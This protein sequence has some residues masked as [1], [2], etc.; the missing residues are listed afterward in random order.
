MPKVL[1][2][3]G[4][5]QPKLQQ[6]SLA[7][8][9]TAT[10]LLAAQ[11][12]AILDDIDDLLGRS[13]VRH[14]SPSQGG[15]FFSGPTGTW[16]TL[17]TDATRLQSKIIEDYRR[18]FAT[19]SVLLRGLPPNAAKEL[20][21]SDET[22]REVVEQ[23]SST[24]IATADEAMAKAH[25]AIEAQRGLLDRLHDAGGGR[26]VFVPD[27]NAL[28]YNIELGDWA[29]PGSSSF[30]LVLAPSV[31][32]ELDELKVGHRNPDVREKAEGLIRRIKGYRGRG[33]LTDGVPLRNPAST[34]R[35]IGTE[36]AMAE[37]L[38]WLDAGNRDDRFIASVIEVMR[39]HARS[40]V[41][42]VT[43]DVNLQNKAEF[44]SLPFV[45]PPD[46]I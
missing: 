19:L 28:L 13:S 46:P 9:A 25:A 18:H 7:S 24:W 11:G 29:F 43:R 36:P 6:L 34:I 30:E 3:L 39:A 45:E 32:V 21:E 8:M 31:L 22:V 16:G 35:S 12:A 41:V 42:I 14:R 37:S 44:A 17:D 4:A 20:S 1:P 38:P 15:V 2:F 5:L 10:D 23:A 26:D 27:T 40:A 33:R